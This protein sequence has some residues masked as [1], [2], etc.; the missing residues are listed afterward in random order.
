MAVLQ[1]EVCKLFIWGYKCSRFEL[2]IT[3]SSVFNK[4]NDADY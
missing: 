1:I 2:I 4:E 3:L